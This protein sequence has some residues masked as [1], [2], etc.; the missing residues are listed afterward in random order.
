MAINFNKKK[1]IKEKKLVM[2]IQTKTKQNKKYE[3]EANMLK[4]T[5]IRTRE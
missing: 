4:N 2:N 3:I 1:C 5:H